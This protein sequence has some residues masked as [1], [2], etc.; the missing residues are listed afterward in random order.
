MQKGYKIKV[1]VFSVIAIFL[2]IGGYIWFT[3]FRVNLKR[4]YYEVV[5]D[6][7]SWLERGDIV[8]VM[9]V[10]KG[11]VEKIDI[12]RDKVVIRFFLDGIKLRKGVKIYVEN[13]G[14][15][16]RKRLVV[17]Q[18]AGEELPPNTRIE[19][20]VIPDLGDLV[21]EGGEIL[22]S[23]KKIVFSL[24]KTVED[25]D[26]TIMEIKKNLILLAKDLKRTS[27]ALRELVEKTSDIEKVIKNLTEI[28]QRIEN[29]SSY[30][31]NEEGSF[32]KLLKDETLYNKIDSTITS[33]NELIKDIRKNPKKY[34]KIEIF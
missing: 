20:G 31:E 27:T 5:V 19:G 34:I 14:F 8:T 23:V 32:G 28:S 33:L 10:N 21:R 22:E 25:A 11:R 12:E 13:Q 29:I 15:L 2:L 9:G 18:G 6:D 24:N 3:E 1:A 4:Y 7:A 26:L 16:G 17:K 30:L